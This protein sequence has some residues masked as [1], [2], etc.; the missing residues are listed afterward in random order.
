MPKLESAQRALSLCVIAAALLLSACA[1]TAT[2]PVASAVAIAEAR[3]ECTRQNA[4]SVAACLNQAS[5]GL[6][7][8]TAAIDDGLTR[9]AMVRAYEDAFRRCPWDDPSYYR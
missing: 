3:C 4:P 2:D 5:N 1:S 7:R 6:Y 8:A 9:T